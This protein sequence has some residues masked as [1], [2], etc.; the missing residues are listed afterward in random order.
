MWKYVRIHTN[1]FHVSLIKIRISIQEEATLSQTGLI[2]GCWE[3]VGLSFVNW[4]GCI[5]IQMGK[6]DLE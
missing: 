4:K 6:E 3:V 2:E 5:A 1:V